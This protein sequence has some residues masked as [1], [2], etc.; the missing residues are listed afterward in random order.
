MKDLTPVVFQGIVEVL[1]KHR[2][3]YVVIGGLGAILQGVAL[4]RTF[5]LDITPADDQ[6]NKKRLA[7]ALRE[8]EAMLRAPGDE[9]GFPIPLD[10]RTFTNMITMTFTT[11]FGPLDVCFVPDGT[12]GYPD[13][14][15]NAVVVERS[16][17]RIPVAA[18]TDIVRSKQ[19]AGR[20]KDAEHLKI[21]MSY[22]EDQQEDPSSNG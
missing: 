6:G 22:L 3:A 10:A 15:E 8:L 20:A 11:R 21:L 17:L 2:V 1:N 14:K 5:D 18:V 12:S 9:K 4:P 13:L 19:A 7:A 16:G